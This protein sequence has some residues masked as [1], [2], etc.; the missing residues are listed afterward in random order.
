[1]KISRL[2]LRSVGVTLFGIPALVKD[3]PASPARFANCDICSSTCDNP[4]LQCLSWNC[5]TVGLCEWTGACMG[6][7][8]RYYPANITCF[9]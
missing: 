7:S 2:L 8:G 6:V 9:W 1:M 5:G 4:Q 3:A